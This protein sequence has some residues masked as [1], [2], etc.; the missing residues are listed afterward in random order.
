MLS[1]KEL[2]RIKLYFLIIFVLFMIYFN[3]SRYTL[4]ANKK[5]YINSNNIEYNSC[6]K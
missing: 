2:R 5:E 3:L 6:Y 1:E 4:Y